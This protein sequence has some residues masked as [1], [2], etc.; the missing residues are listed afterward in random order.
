M[1]ALICEDPPVSSRLCAAVN[2]ARIC[3]LFHRAIFVDEYNR[4]RCNACCRGAIRC[5]IIDIGI[6]VFTLFVQG[7]K[8][9]DL[10]SN[11]VLLVL[12]ASGPIIIL[13]RDRIIGRGAVPRSDRADRDLPWVREIENVLI[14]GIAAD[15][16]AVLRED[17]FK[18]E[19]FF[20]GKRF[21]LTCRVIK[22]IVVTKR[23]ERQCVGALRGSSQRKQCKRHGVK[24]FHG[25]TF[26]FRWWGKA[27][28][29][30]VNADLLLKG[31]IVFLAACG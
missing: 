23:R 12:E 2:S 21:A 10:G 8:R 24:K 4:V 15:D 16:F 19:V 25:S 30:R 27:L 6:D 31:A 17:C 9:D 14:I 26:P 18:C 20:Y 22:V 13:P 5:N 28:L 1:R 7:L 3:R 11:G 29:E